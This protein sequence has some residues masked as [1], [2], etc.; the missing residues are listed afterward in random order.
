MQLQL[1]MSHYALIEQWNFQHYF[2]IKFSSALT[3]ADISISSTVTAAVSAALTKAWA[4]I[5]PSAPTLAQS[6]P[7]ACS[8]TAAFNARA[9]SRYSWSF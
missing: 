2:N 1:S 3:L 6:T 5:L 8:D 4:Q 7:P 9:E